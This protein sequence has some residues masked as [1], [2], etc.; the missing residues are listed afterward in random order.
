MSHDTIY[1]ESLKIINYLKGEHAQTRFW[2][3]FEIT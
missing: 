3:K 2:F 1:T